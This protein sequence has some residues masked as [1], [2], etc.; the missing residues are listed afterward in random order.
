MTI[1]Q[2]NDIRKKNKTNLPKCVVSSP[3]VGVDKKLLFG[4]T[5][6]EFIRKLQED[7]CV[8][9]YVTLLDSLHFPPL[10]HFHYYF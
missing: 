4:P 9:H 6:P 10:F 3:L 2:D 5:R 1:A 7:L 8:H